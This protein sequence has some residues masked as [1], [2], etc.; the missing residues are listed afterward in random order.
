MAKLDENLQYAI[1]CWKL[2]CDRDNRG[3][4]RGNIENLEKAVIAFKGFSLQLET[5]LN[6]LKNEDPY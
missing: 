3:D 4:Q 1:D 5:H 6:K 2:A